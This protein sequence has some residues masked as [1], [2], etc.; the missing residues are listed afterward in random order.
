MNGLT[1]EQFSLNKVK[2]TKNGGLTAIFDATISV[3]GSTFVNKE[4]V[5]SV[6]SPH[7]DLKL[8]LSMFQAK[9]AECWRQGEGNLEFVS[10]RGLAVS[11]QSDNIG[12]IIIGMFDSPG[13]VPMSMISHRLRFSGSSYGWEDELEELTAAVETET[14]EYLYN[15]KAAQ[16]EIP[17]PQIGGSPS[18]DEM[19]FEAVPV[20]QAPNDPEEGLQEIKAKPAKKGKAKK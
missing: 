12:V 3:G 17:F 9:L 10:V 11:G 20:G 2:L 4:T 1:R 19:D 16:L 6:K 8:A 13:G 5:E 15:G 7:P 14:W 18:A